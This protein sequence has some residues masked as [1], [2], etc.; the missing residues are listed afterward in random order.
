[1]MVDAADRSHLTEV[2]WEQII[3]ERS[4]APKRWQTKLI[5]ASR[6]NTAVRALE[7]LERLWNG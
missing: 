5:S 2:E 6:G 1:M 4:E 7:M 3:M